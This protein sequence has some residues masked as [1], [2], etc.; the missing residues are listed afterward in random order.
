MSEKVVIGFAIPKELLKK[1]K[2]KAKAE[3]RTK[4]AM[5]RWILQQALENGS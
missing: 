3:G 1:L 2:A 5:A 4:S